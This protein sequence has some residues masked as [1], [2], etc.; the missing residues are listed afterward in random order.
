[1][2]NNSTV[3][4]L[5]RTMRILCSVAILG[6]PLVLALAW[7]QLDFLL[8]NTP[9]LRDLPI[10]PET[11]TPFVQI[12]GFFVSMGAAGIILYGLIRLRHLFRL[13]EQGTFFTLTAIAHL[14]AFAFSI[15]ASAI[16]SPIAGG[17]LSLLIT[18]NNPPGKHALAISMGSAELQT[19]FIGGVFLVIAHILCEGRRL[20]EENAQIV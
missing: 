14:R 13:F 7:W 18:M 16:V 3:A 10:Y 17:L 8:E 1:M 5:S 2:M 9:E 20:A 15:L 4:R 11:I 6:I 12:A 19:A